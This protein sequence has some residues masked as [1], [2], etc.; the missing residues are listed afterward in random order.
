MI[1]QRSPKFCLTSAYR[2]VSYQPVFLQLLGSVTVNS[3]DKSTR[4]DLYILKAANSM[5]QLKNVHKENLT[6]SRHETQRQSSLTL[7]SALQTPGEG[8]RSLTCL[9][10]KMNSH[11]SEIK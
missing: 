11:S 1:P 6:A 9:L 2:S 7:E 3:V 10:I 4:S 5:E 8:R